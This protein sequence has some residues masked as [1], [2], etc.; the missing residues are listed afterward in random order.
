MRGLLID[1]LAL[2]SLGS[3]AAG[4]AG[5]SWQLAAVVVGVIGLVLA[6]ALQLLERRS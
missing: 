2:G 4:L 6:V 5:W 1:V 3:L